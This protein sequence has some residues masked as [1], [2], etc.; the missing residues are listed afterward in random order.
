MQSEQ[1][2][3]NPVEQPVS[4]KFHR[5]LILGGTGE[6]LQIADHLAGRPDLLVTSSL[7]GRV[8]ESKKPSGLVRIGGFGGVDGLTAYLT[9]QRIQIVIDATHPYAAQMSHHAELACQQAQ[10]PLIAFKRAAWTAQPQDRWLHAA[11][12]CDAASMID[13][14]QCRVFLSI[15]R[16]ELSAFS[17]CDKA[18]FLIRAIEEPQVRLP[19]KSR[20][21]LSRGPFS[22]DE[23]KKILRREDITHVVTKNSGGAA[24]YAKIQAARDLG[25]EVV[26][27]ARPAKGQTV[28]LQQ[29]HEVHCK[30]EELL[31]NLPFQSLNLAETVGP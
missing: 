7:A 11:D 25:I 18:W 9:S 6:A 10:V 20:V 29:L 17:R 24:T 2:L 27:I 4:G 19:Q 21:I 30:L 26:M 23:E 16:Q 12:F 28:A 31:D 8:N 15:G 3:A 13:N 22:L 1:R 14:E 5:V